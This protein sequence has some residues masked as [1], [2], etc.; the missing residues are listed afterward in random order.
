[1][2]VTTLRRTSRTESLQLGT[3]KNNG[4]QE[5]FFDTP[6]QE[7]QTFSVISIPDDST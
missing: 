4:G 5:D 6:P 1:M 7:R 3:G 2:V